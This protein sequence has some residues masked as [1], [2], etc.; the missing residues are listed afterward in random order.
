MAGLS[1]ATAARALPGALAAVTDELY[2]LPVKQLA[3]EVVVQADDRV[4]SCHDPRTRSRRAQTMGGEARQ[5]GA[6]QEVDC[7]ALPRWRV[8]EPPRR[9]HNRFDVEHRNF[10]A[11]REVVDGFVE[12]RG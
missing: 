10:A 4:L 6:P 9:G 12:D 8:G 2:V 1:S 11:P 3:D 7:H 5:R